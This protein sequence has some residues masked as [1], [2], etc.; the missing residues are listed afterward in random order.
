[1]LDYEKWRKVY[2][3]LFSHV[4]PEE[5]P[6]PFYDVDQSQAISENP[7]SF[8]QHEPYLRREL[9][10]RMVDALERRLQELNI[11]E[12]RGQDVI[13]C[14]TDAAHSV[15]DDLVQDPCWSSKP[16]Q[17]SPASIT[18]NVLDEVAQEPYLPSDQPSGVSASGWPAFGPDFL[19]DNRTPDGLWDDDSGPQIEMPNFDFILNSIIY[20]D[21]DGQNINSEDHNANLQDQNAA[22]KEI[23]DSGYNSI[24]YDAM[25]HMKQT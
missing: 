23:S 17:D 7:E 24:R 25:R 4:K 13:K 2:Q 10:S 6:S 1:M 18:H 11:D 5:I 12:E 8:V 9:L 20:N 14:C 3:I 22:R 16:H 21:Q 15:L 19:L